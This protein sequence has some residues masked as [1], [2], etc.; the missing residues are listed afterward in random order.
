MQHRKDDSKSAP[1]HGETQS[2]DDQ[3]LD[4][5]SSG[6]ATQRVRTLTVQELERLSKDDKRRP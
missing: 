3:V 5:V 4:G 1:D 2:L 6:D